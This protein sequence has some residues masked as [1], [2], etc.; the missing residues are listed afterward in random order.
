LLSTLIK[1]RWCSFQPFKDLLVYFAKQS[2]LTDLDRDCGWV[3]NAKLYE[4]ARYA[5]KAATSLQ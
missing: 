1:T 2:I 5:R 3:L 4:A